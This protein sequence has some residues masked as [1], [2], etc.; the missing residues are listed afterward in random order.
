MVEAPKRKKGSKRRGFV[1]WLA[2]LTI[3]IC[4]GTVGLV[5]VLFQTQKVVSAPDWLKKRVEQRLNELSP[6]IEFEFDD[7]SFGLTP[8]AEPT[9]ELIG[10]SVRQP[11]SEARL[12]S[13]GSIRIDLDPSVLLQREMRPLRMDISQC[14]LVV[15]RDRSGAFD[16]S[17]G[18][19]GGAFYIE[20]I[21]MIIDN[22]EAAI[23]TSALG[24]IERATARDITILFEDD[25]H[26]HIT[27]TKEGSISFT[28]DTKGLRAEVVLNVPG[29]EDR[30]A[31]IS[32]VAE[33]E[34]GTSAASIRTNATDVNTSFFARHE[35]SAVWL[36]S[37]NAPISSEASVEINDAGGFGPLNTRLR[38]GAG[39]LQPNSAT[40]PVKLDGIEAEISYDLLTGAVKLPALRVQSD[41]LTVSGSGQVFLQ[42]FVDARPQA[43]VAQVRIDALQSPAEDMFDF[44]LVLQDGA[45]DLHFQFNPFTLR[46]GQASISDGKTRI[47]AKGH[48]TALPEGWK[49]SLDAYAD[50]LS[51][52]NLVGYWPKNVAP[53]ARGW[54][55][56]N[57]FEGVGK[58]GYVAARIAPGEA[59]KVNVGF[60]FEEAT[61]GFIPNFPPISGG[62]G[63]GV[64]SG[65]SLS[66]TVANGVVATGPHSVD[67][68]GSVVQIPDMR[69]RPA[70]G[71]VDLRTTSELT[72]LLSLLDQAPL[73][74]I[75]RA[76]RSATLANGRATAQ[77][78]LELPFTKHTRAKDVTF[79]VSGTIEHI[80]SDALIPD[81]RLEAD[82]MHVGADPQT[83]WVSGAGTVD[84]AG[85][86][87]NWLQP[88]GV[89]YQN[90]SIVKGEVTLSPQFAQTFNV[91]VAPE[92]LSG[93][94]SAS[95][96]LTLPTEG[97]AQYRMTSDLMGLG[98]AIDALKWR[99][100]EGE[101]VSLDV[102]GELGSPPSVDRLSMDGAGLTLV[103]S[104]GLSPDG[105][106]QRA[107][108]DPLRVGAWLNGRAEITGRGAGLAPEI[109]LTGSKLDLR[110]LG[111]GGNGR[112]GG[113]P[114]SVA[115]ERVQLNDTYF[116][117]ALKGQL[118][119][120]GS[121][122]RISGLLNG[123]AS[124]SVAMRP[125]EFGTA[126]E[127]SAADGS[128]VL[129]AIDLL[130]NGKGGPLSVSLVP[131][132]EKGAFNGSLQFKDLGVRGAPVLADML[133]AISVV[134]LLEQMNGRGIVFND[135]QSDFVL[136]PDR[137]IITKGSAV[138]SSLGVSLDGTYYLAE[139][140]MDLQGVISPVYLVNS[141]GSGLTRKGEGL[142]GFSY[143]LTGP[144][145]DPKVS[146]NPL[147]LL[148]PGMFRSI[149][150]KAP[151]EVSQ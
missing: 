125:S 91:G 82:I 9:I 84:G 113:A 108:F 17:M 39:V 120:A 15:R 135:V 71:I 56:N 2:G 127:L 44:P 51:P 150:R 10:A 75:E 110:R 47:R 101:P 41:L 131:R 14:R 130:E 32:L 129:T 22:V 42:D 48:A 74:L 140:S 35:P 12:A 52:E 69:I 136:T 46:V 78:R 114:M 121:P 11:G 24:S 134:G 143:R 146:V 102:V 139:K 76:G 96:T 72:S 85:F 103:G 73:R 30:K 70:P 118:G 20:D 109:A 40:Q 4:I 83:L 144:A 133:G 137:L 59:P 148:T 122:D 97:A 58:N 55:A 107:T 66:V 19:T 111:A 100:T 8:Q 57:I 65:N 53:K 36:T 142:F 67:I 68:S 27:E 43:L 45:V 86:D 94:S 50:Q 151:P 128:M 13:F 7:V 145:N 105:G 26:G 147:S 34:F 54:L 149:F 95:V 92:D 116:M 112:A 63:H 23:A 124:V 138:G 115:F 80:V 16:L 90:G 88:L 141:V 49:V 98:L 3:L 89:A 106:L 104:V 77:A 18:S 64:I 25:L 132:A 123:R 1:L 5:G 87:V 126:Y 29:Y 31:Q 60:E 37:L 38:I 81:R 6:D 119:Q 33:S 93:K 62:R 21:P 99:K 117:T 61:V 28:Q 79:D